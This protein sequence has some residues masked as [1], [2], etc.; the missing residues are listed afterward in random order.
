MVVDIEFDVHHKDKDISKKVSKLNEEKM[1]KWALLW[2]LLK[3][4]KNDVKSEPE[5]G[6][7]KWIT[8]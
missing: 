5:G 7:I 1:E 3:Y 8:S 2:C 4:E 6:F